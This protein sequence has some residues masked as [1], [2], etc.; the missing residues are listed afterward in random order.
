MILLRVKCYLGLTLR[1]YGTF[2]IYPLKVKK[3]FPEEN[4]Y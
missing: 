1:V 4:Y 3:Q 2:K